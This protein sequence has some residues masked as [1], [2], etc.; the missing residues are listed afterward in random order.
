MS[1]IEI[2]QSG[3]EVFARD[4]KAPVRG[5]GTRI[6]PS[7]PVGDDGSTLPCIWKST[8]VT[9]AEMSDGSKVPAN[10]CLLLVS[11]SPPTV[12]RGIVPLAAWQLFG[13]CL[14]EW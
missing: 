7:V 6:V 8:E 5:G 12:M 3:G 13:E 9:Q 11:K 4:L 14:V 10:E 2:P 1:T